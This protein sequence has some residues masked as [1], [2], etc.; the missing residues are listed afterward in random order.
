MISLPIELVDKILNYVLRDLLDQM[1]HFGSLPLSILAEFR[2][3]YSTCKT[4]NHCLE[5]S[6]PKLYLGGYRD[7]IRNREPTPRYF[8]VPPFRPATAER[9]KE[10]PRSI[11]T[12]WPKVFQR[13][14][15]FHV[16]NV[17]HNFH[18]QTTKYYEQLGKFWLNPSLKIG[19][20]HDLF[21]CKNGCRVNRA[22]LLLLLEQ[23]YV[24]QWDVELWNQPAEGEWRIKFAFNRRQYECWWEGLENAD[25]PEIKNVRGSM[26]GDPEVRAVREWKARYDHQFSG[27]NIAPD[28][29]VWWVWRETQFLKT[30]VA[31]YHEGKA[32]VFDLM[33]SYLFTNFEPLEK[34]AGCGDWE[35]GHTSYQKHWQCVYSG[36]GKGVLPNDSDVTVFKGPGTDALTR[37]TTVDFR[38]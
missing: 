16:N 22:T 10:Y 13:F 8:Y 9:E 24:R 7:L 23:L 12:S 18:H 29:K 17:H 4:F 34:I 28:V 5:H 20:L 36:P 21:R 2:T 3:L 11:T 1:V 33:I 30:W 14:Q 25:D 26:Y 6:R 35:K 19:D 37:V 27:A 32:W 31:G 15:C 38:L